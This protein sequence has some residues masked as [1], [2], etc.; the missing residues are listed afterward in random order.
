MIEL[1]QGDDLLAFDGAPIKVTIINPDDLYIK[2]AYIVI[3]P[4]D[5]SIVKEYDEPSDEI[6]V[7]LNSTDTR[8]LKYQNV[9]KLVLIDSLGR[10]RTCPEEFR[11][12]AKQEVYHVKS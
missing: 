9:M 8:K 7:D 3:N 4:G 2:K 11:F 6:I 10:K 5:Q 1:Y 12:I